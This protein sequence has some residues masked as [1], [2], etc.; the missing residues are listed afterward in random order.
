MHTGLNTGIVVAGNVGSDLR[1]NYSVIG[2]TVNLASRLEHVA[3]KGEVVIS[4]ETYRVV[5]SLVNT[6][7][8]KRLRS[9]ARPSL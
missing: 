9:K 5:S 4:E 8:R 3:A 1:M 2:D 7:S 6:K